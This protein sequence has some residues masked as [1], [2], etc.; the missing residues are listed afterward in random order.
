MST[1]VEQ[2]TTAHEYGYEAVTV[3]PKASVTLA[4]IA[5]MQTV[6][7]DE[8]G[9]NKQGGNYKYKTEADLLSALKPI[10]RKHNCIMLF[11]AVDA[12]ASSGFFNS[13]TK[14]DNTPRDRLMTLSFAV[15]KLR[16]QC[17]TDREDYVEVYC[18]GFKADQVSDKALGATTIAKRYCMMQLAAIPSSGDDDPDNGE[19]S[20]LMGMLYGGGDNKPPQPAAAPQSAAPAVKPAGNTFI[21]SL[22][23]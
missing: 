3:S 16:L 9:Q 18:P 1:Q 15:M 13:Q 11:G 6:A 4:C 23:S 20:N 14:N 5:E 7:S 22:L 19:S 10:A 8:S 2:F 17:V 21:N 12:Q